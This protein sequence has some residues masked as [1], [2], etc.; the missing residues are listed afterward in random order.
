M[1]IPSDPFIGALLDERYSVDA[2]IAKGGMATVYRGTDT[3]LGR[4]VAI[5]IL[6]GTFSRDTDFVNRFVQEA[7]SAAVLTHPNVVAVHDQGVFQGFP[8][9]V[10]EY[11]PG[12]TV[13]E[14]LHESRVLTSAHALEIMRPVLAGLAAAHA[15]GFIH[16][17]IKPENVLVTE[18]GIVKL[19]DFGLARVISD[20]PVSDS[21]GAVLL[22]T[23]AYLSPEQVQQQRLDQRSDVYSAGILLFEMLTG[24][25]PFTGNSPLDVAYK[26]VNSSVPAPSTLQ[27]D[28]PPAIDHLV[29]AATQRDPNERLQSAEEFL[30]A[31][32]RAASAVPQAEALTT[33]IPMNPTVVMARPAADSIAPHM[34]HRN[35]Q[36]PV[37]EPF[38]ARRKPIKLM[39]AGVAVIALAYFGFSFIGNSIPVPN[40]VGKTSEEAQAT[41]TTAELKFVIEEQFSEDVPAGSI[42]QTKPGAETKTRKGKDVTL[43]VSKGPERYIIPSDLA[44]QDPNAAS[45]ALK[46]LTLEISGTEDVFDDKIETGKVVGT[47]PA[48]GEQVKRGTPVK[49]LVSKGP[50]PVDIPKILGTDI[51]KVTT[52]LGELGLSVVVADQIFDDSPAG[53][54]ISSD[55]APGTSV[56]KGTQ[57]KVTISKGPALVDVPNVVGKKTDDAKKTLEAL[58]FVVVTE[59]K[60]TAVVLN[61]VYEQS[62]KGSAPKG[63]T[64]TLKIA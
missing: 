3:R 23:M 26:H 28:V 59:N 12:R 6:A 18:N 24:R 63:S 20:I 7:R 17:D 8:F 1:S 9:L 52:Q 5:K 58:G 22:G 13:R 39:A 25:V 21:T 30:D 56:P 43:V 32:N 60:F 34:Q 51:Q 15:A 19:T 64:I 14:I 10:M 31:A 4:L 36:Q 45:D 62:V 50:A 46:A 37:A 54:V 42:I 11:V 53:Q 44:G 49:I 27:P 38:V 57:V 16:R 33:V 41:L 48:A 2:L 47:N 29:L 55:P 61:V 35:L 40:V